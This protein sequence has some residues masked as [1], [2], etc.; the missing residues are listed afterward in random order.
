[1]GRIVYDIIR[2]V[3][4]SIIGLI[5]AVVT[6]G[7]SQVQGCFLGCVFWGSLL[8][9]VCHMLGLGPPNMKVQAYKQAYDDG[10]IAQE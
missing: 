10:L 9:I 5:K 3:I 8:C 7:L 4:D 2:F 6:Q 1:M